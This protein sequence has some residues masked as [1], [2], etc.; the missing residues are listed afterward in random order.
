LKRWLRLLTSAIRSPELMK[1][2]TVGLATTTLDTGMFYSLINLTALGASGANICSYSCGVLLSYLLNRNWT[3]KMA[4]GAG[5]WTAYAARF[6]ASNA[7][8]LAISTGI[9]F[10]LSQILPELWAKVISLPVI[11]SWNFGMAKY[12]VFG[13][14]R[15]VK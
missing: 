4:A 1:F 9:V 8:G 15:A 3:F 13:R 12:W 5:T 7:A 11:F 2:A 6:V 10:G 14:T